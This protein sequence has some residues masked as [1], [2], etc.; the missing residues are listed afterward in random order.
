M[1]NIFKKKKSDNEKR[2]LTIQEKWEIDSK[3]YSNPDI[4]IKTGESQCYN[5]SYRIKGN[6]LKCELFENI[7]KNILFG[8]TRCDYYNAKNDEVTK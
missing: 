4:K 3:S 6:S 7:D 5:C 2:Q 1:F 8:K